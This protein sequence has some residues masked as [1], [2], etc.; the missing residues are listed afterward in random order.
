M[1]ARSEGQGWG[2]SAPGRRGSERGD[3]PKSSSYIHAQ[4]RSGALKARAKPTA[5]VERH[6][7][8]ARA[9]ASEDM[10]SHSQWCRRHADTFPGMYRVAMEVCIIP[11]ARR[12]AS[13][14]RQGQA[15]AQPDAKEDGGSHAPFSYHMQ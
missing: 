9:A 1:R 2:S 5:D 11:A 14:S 6:L 8:L 3:P 15:A 12:V 4:S 13:G 10:N 7:E